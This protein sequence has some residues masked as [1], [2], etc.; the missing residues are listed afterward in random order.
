[1]RKRVLSGLR[2]FLILG[3]LAVLMPSA[4][5][6]PLSSARPA[7]AKPEPFTVL[8]TQNN[9]TGWAIPMRLGRDRSK[10]SLWGDGYDNFGLVHVHKG[11]VGHGKNWP[12]TALMVAQ[13]KR[14][15]EKPSGI[16]PDQYTRYFTHYIRCDEYGAFGL[17]VRVTVE[18]V[19]D[20][21][22]LPDRLPVGIKTAWQNVE[23]F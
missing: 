21:R 14:A 15:L 16:F 10:P 7:T 3:I 13:V 18:V 20:T 2:P 8:W 1:M 6:T 23:L 22:V 5:A 19:V 12:S 9:P 17:R 4:G 11:H